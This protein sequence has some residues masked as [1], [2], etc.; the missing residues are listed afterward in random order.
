MGLTEFVERR[1]Y[2]PDERRVPLDVDRLSTR[3]AD[4]PVQIP[5]QLPCHAPAVNKHRFADSHIYPTLE[6][7]V[8]ALAM[9][10]SQE[11][12]PEVRTDWTLAVHGPNSPFRH[13]TVIKKYVD[14]LLNR[15]G[16]QDLV[17]Y[18][19]TVERAVKNAETG[20]WE[21]TLRRAAEK[22]GDLDYWWTES[23]DKLVVASG[24]FSVPYV[25][26]I[27]GLKEFTARH[28]EKVLHTKQYRGPEGYEGKVLSPLS[29]LPI[30]LEVIR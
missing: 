29:F 7:N 24:R 8:S 16:Y 25:P 15:N 20:K 17:V 9:A 18:N 26:P 21:L 30:T 19:T 6:T 14:D 5:P 13:H 4:T 1:I 27:P 3:T 28:P 22:D 11:P 10:Y 23:F 12:I 2:R